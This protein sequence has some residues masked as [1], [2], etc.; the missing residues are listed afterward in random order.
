MILVGNKCNIV[1]STNYKTQLD[2]IALK[3]NVNILD[4]MISAKNWKKYWQING[5]YY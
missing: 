2:N 4:F 5:L 1:T 3:F